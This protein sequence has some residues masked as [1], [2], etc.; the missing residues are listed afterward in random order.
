MNAKKIII[1]LLILLVVGGT[2]WFFLLRP[3]SIS[4]DSVTASFMKHEEAFETVAAYLDENDISAEITGFLSIDNSYGIVRKESTE[5]R[6]F[7]EAVEELI[8]DD[9]TEI[10]SDGDTVEFVYHSTG[11]YFNKL[12][13]SVI[14]NG[15]EK[16]EGKITVP[17]N[18]NGWHLYLAQE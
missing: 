18:T 12:Y 1:T 17:L 15:Q 6:A 7:A 3:E 5:F 10:I 9:C 13:G 11:G 2:A 14:F 4:Q 16:V 8:S